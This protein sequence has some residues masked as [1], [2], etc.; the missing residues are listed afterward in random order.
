MTENLHP[1]SQYIDIDKPDFER[2]VTISAEH[3]GSLSIIVK[4]WNP[5]KFENGGY[6][7]AV[8][9]DG[10]PMPR[11]SAMPGE[12]KLDALLNAVAFVGETLS[13]RGLVDAW[14]GKSLG[15]FPLP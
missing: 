12:D 1:V 4:I 15:G 13:R 5:V 3:A 7:S 11:F 10:L 9:I 14:A 8:S 2:E 6:V